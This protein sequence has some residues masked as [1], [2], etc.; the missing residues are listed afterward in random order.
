MD[1]PQAAK[2][3]TAEDFITMIFLDTSA[4]IFLLRGELP[5]PALHSETLAI[6]TVVE[7][8]LTLGVLHGGKQKEALKVKSFLKDVRIYA[9]DRAAAR[10][11]AEVLAKLWKCGEPI[12]D[13]DTQIAGH[14]LSLSLPV[15]TDNTKH[16]RRVDGLEVLSWSS[17]LT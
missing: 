11:T 2:Q 12:G 13:F 8:E 16:F 9:F 10:S 5:D 3:D 15:L 14:A 17:G 1:R 6:S 7:M 4:A